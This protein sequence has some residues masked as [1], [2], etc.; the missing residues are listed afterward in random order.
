[1]EIK[2]NEIIE[3]EQNL[4]NCTLQDLEKYVSAIEKRYYN[5]VVTKDS[6][7]SLKKNRAEMNKLL[8]ALNNKKKKIKED[9][10]Q[11][12][13]QM[14]SEYDGYTERICE[15]KNIIDQGIKQIDKID[16]IEKFERINIF[17]KEMKEMCGFNFELE[18]IFDSKWLNKNVSDSKWQK[19]LN[20]AALIFHNFLQSN[21]NE[22]E[23]EILNFSVS[24]N[25]KEKE[26]IMNFLKEN[27]I[28]YNIF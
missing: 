13:Q 20:D 26:M 22:D 6:Y 16:K 15:C 5:V 21:K 28:E 25:K 24:V 9:I 4:P 27:N 23:N 14:F 1:M 3:F 12:Y 10:L 8:D 11:P 18:N 2:N 19:E 7:S 17:F